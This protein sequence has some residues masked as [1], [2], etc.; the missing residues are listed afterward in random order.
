MSS[1]SFPSYAHLGLCLLPPQAK[2]IGTRPR[3]ADLDAAVGA[4]YAR[5][6]GGALALEH[7]LL[8][9][10]ARL[11]QLVEAA[12]VAAEEAG[13]YFLG[14]GILGEDAPLHALLE[15]KQDELRGKGLRK[16]AGRCLAGGGVGLGVQE[17][18]SRVAST[19]ERVSG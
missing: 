1:I 13:E 14:D 4:A 7:N 16:D 9:R 11:R 12:A 18:G 19:G 2:H 10:R 15:G 17:M 3:V 5:G 8:A 6:D